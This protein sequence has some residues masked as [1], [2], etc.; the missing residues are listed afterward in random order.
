MLNGTS[1][2]FELEM[3][4]TARCLERDCK[5][6]NPYVN[7]NFPR[8]LEYPKNINFT[9]VFDRVVAL[10]VSYT[11]MVKYRQVTS[12]GFGLPEGR[13]GRF[14]DEFLEVSSE[15]SPDHV[16]LSPDA[17]AKKVT[18]TLKAG[19]NVTSG[20][21]Y[22]RMAIA[23]P[24]YVKTVEGDPLFYLKII[25]VRVGIDDE[26]HNIMGLQKAFTPEQQ[27]GL[28]AQYP[29]IKISERF[30]NSSWFTLKSNGALIARYDGE[31]FQQGFWDIKGDKIIFMLPDGNFTGR[32]GIGSDI[33]LYDN[34]VWRY[35]G[36]DA[37]KAVVV[38]AWRHSDPFSPSGFCSVEKG[39]VGNY[40]NV[41]TYTLTRE[42][43]ASLKFT[44]TS[45]RNF[46]F[47]LNLNLSLRQPTL[48]NGTTIRDDIKGVKASFSPNPLILQIGGQENFTVV[49]TANSDAPD[50]LYG[51]EFDSSNSPLTPQGYL[52][53]LY[54][55]HSPIGQG[56]D[57][58]F[59]L[60]VTSVCPET[61][62]EG[63]KEVTKEVEKGVTK[64]PSKEVGIED[65]ISYFDKLKQV[66][67]GG[68]VDYLTP[69]VAIMLA[70]VVLAAVIVLP[71]KMKPK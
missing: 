24:N 18:V 58:S 12:I 56:T 61:I 5:G 42:T 2:S 44:V 59:F 17:P 47:P 69:L 6:L 40:P 30:A 3:N 11:P 64:Q 68:H 46:S 52:K 7:Q 9:L 49:F 35:R 63:R 27:R 31:K 10:G 37:P 41:T 23:E 38:E 1:A 14:V 19:S 16:A 71:R 51:I 53:P 29:N 28:N 67:S 32:K 20:L 50:G 8:L 33:V 54:E 15:I 34:S 70:V 55:G 45:T 26:Y 13:F 36:L 65:S 62:R 48:E 66:V 39:C 25:N 57:V 43:S 22:I 21:Y 4:L 60:K